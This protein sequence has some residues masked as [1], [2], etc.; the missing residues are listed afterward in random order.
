MAV[1]NKRSG[2]HAEA[3]TLVLELP[4]SVTLA[5]DW[6]TVGLPPERPSYQPPRPR[7]AAWMHDGPG[8]GLS[9]S[10]ITSPASIASRQGDLFALTR[11]LLGQPGDAFDDSDW[12]ATN[13]GRTLEISIG[14]VHGDRS[15]PVREP[16]LVSVDGAGQHEL[17]WV[18]YSKSGSRPA[19]G[20]IVRA[21]PR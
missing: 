10:F 19:Y 16:L 1:H 17:R 5:D 4:N 3:V 20:T 8:I 21:V 9:P 11:G 14:D 13:A 7:R 15:V 18:L 12:K 2:A 6:P